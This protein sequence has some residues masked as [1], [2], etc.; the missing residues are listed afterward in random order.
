MRV[1]SQHGRPLRLP[2]KRVFPLDLVRSGSAGDSYVLLTFFCPSMTP[3]APGVIRP[4]R[5]LAKATNSTLPLAGHELFRSL[6]EVSRVVVRQVG[7]VA[8]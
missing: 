4:A 8:H 3:L 7:L 2:V 1:L 6:R 5:V